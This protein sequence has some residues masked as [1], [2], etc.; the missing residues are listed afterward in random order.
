MKTRILGNSGVSLSVI[1]LGTWAIGGGGWKFSWGPQDD[2]EST[3]AIS[4]AMD[5]GINWIDTAPVYG[6]GHAEQVVGRALQRINKKPFIATKCGLV[7]DDRRKITGCLKRE[8]IRREAEQS[9]RRLKIETIDLYQ[10]HWPNPDSD[11]E[12]AWEAVGELISEGKV[13]YAGVSNFNLEQLNRISR[14]RQPVSLQNPYSILECDLEQELI[15]HCAGAAGGIGILAYS[16]MQKGLLTGGFTRKRIEGLSPDDHRRRDAHF[17]EPRLGVNLELVA[18]LQVIASNKNITIGQLAVAWV[19]RQEAVTSA[20]V[21]TRRPEQ[22]E[23][24]V[25][26]GEITLTNEEKEAIDILLR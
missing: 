1:G 24:I 21:G 5:L 16:P 20:I 22:I 26:A 25:Q 13:R 3:A 18:K 12:E 23:E 9:L 2:K 17:R 7:W 6:L 8:S 14:I 19:L 11:I 10:I 4:R 15:G